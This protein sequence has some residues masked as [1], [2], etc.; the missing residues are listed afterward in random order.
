[1]LDRAE[2]GAIQGLMSRM[3]RIRVLDGPDYKEAEYEMNNSASR[4]NQRNLA[5]T[6]GSSL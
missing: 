2:S 4:E 3:Y 6:S 5:S 1:M